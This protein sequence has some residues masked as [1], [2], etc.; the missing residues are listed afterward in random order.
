MNHI[1]PIIPNCIIGATFSA[2]TSELIYRQLRKQLKSD[3]DINLMIKEI[4]G[5]KPFEMGNQHPSRIAMDVL[6]NASELSPDQPSTDIALSELLPN[7]TG[8]TSNVPSNSEASSNVPIPLSASNSTQPQSVQMTGTDSAPADC[9]TDDE[10][11]GTYIYE[12]RQQYVALKKLES[13][14]YLQHIRDRF[15]KDRKSTPG[16]KDEDIAL[17]ELRLDELVGQVG[18]KLKQKLA[19]R[20]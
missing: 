7:S 19:D 17:F 16:F 15:A 14:R 3:E 4:M 6:R 20:M 9:N 8:R 2:R 10:K 5:E 1:P 11:P 12:I 13:R 18:Q